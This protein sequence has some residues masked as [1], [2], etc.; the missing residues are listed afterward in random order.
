MKRLLAILFAVSAY[1]YVWDCNG[2]KLLFTVFWGVIRP[3]KQI[4]CFLSY[5][6]LQSTYGTCLILI[7]DTHPTNSQPPHHNWAIQSWQSYHPLSQNSERVRDQWS[8]HDKTR[9]RGAQCPMAPHSMCKHATHANLHVCM[10]KPTPDWLN[11]SFSQYLNMKS[12]HG[13]GVVYVPVGSDE[14]QIIYFAC[15]YLFIS[16]ISLNF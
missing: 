11:T 2:L 5:K 7:F 9:Y 12:A 13:W 14:K 1:I 4:F 8:Y 10:W 3:H 16:N 15:P 6:I